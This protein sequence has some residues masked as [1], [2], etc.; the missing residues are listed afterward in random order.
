MPHGG[1]L[2]TG[3]LASNLRSM[4]DTPAPAPTALAIAPVADRIVFALRQAGLLGVALLV[5]GTVTERLRPDQSL[6]RGI[7]STA[8]LWAIV[9]WLCV[10]LFNAIAFDQLFN[11]IAFD[12][13]RS[14]THEGIAL[15]V[16]TGIGV[17]VFF[18]GLVTLNDGSAGRRFVYLL[19]TSLG[20]IMFWWAMISLG[21]LVT[22]HLRT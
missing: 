9:L 20:T 10:L 21:F 1:P 22:K 3:S 15:Y 18:T 19:A 5:A 11:A 7:A 13:P 14:H 6:D 12:Q 16:A 2:R 8:F 4:T 17:L